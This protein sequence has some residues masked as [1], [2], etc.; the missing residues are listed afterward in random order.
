[1]AAARN[2]GLRN[3]LPGTDVVGFLDSDDVAPPGRFDS[4]LSLLAADPGLEL[5]YGRLRLVREV[6]EETLTPL[7]GAA[8]PPLVGVSMSSGLFR[9]GLMDRIG[10][11]DTSLQQAEDTDYLLRIFET[12][13]RFLQTETLTVF[14]MRHDGNMTLD[15]ATTMKCFAKALHLSMRRRRT[16]PGRVL[17]MP[18][19]SLEPLRAGIPA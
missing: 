15:S 19:F 5:T 18:S 12:G 17:V 4:D 8:G 9:R 6:D 13:A 14:Y 1:V 3:L 7:E 16:D 2:A 11:F 10:L